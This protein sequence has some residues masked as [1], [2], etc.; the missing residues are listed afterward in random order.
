MAERAKELMRGESGSA[1]LRG[2][3]TAKEAGQ[4]AGLGKQLVILAAK[5]GNL[6]AN[7]LVNHSGRARQEG[8]SRVVAAPGT[9]AAVLGNLL[10]KMFP[11]FGWQ[12]AGVPGQ[13][14]HL[15]Q[16]GNFL[17][18]ALER[19]SMQFRSELGSVAWPLTDCE[20]VANPLGFEFQELLLGQIIEGSHNPFARRAGLGRRGLQINCVPGLTLGG[21]AK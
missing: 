20:A 21:C 10:A 16:A 13:V 19:A 6:L 2:R 4:R 8:C 5:L 7:G 15:M 18:L 14:Q 11:Q 9:M 3:D 17:F 1:D 12:T